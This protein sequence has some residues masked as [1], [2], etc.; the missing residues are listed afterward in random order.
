MQYPSTKSRGSIFWAAV[1]MFFGGII[2]SFIPFLGPFVVGIVGGK[3]AG[4]VGR[5]ITAALL[6]AIVLAILILAG[7]AIL[8]PFGVA[9]GVLAGLGII[10]IAIF[11]SL[12][13]LLGAIIGG[14]L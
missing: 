14:V 9:F 2:F 12:A 4:G 8:H 7:S 3:I 13:L 10:L 5:G 11:H 6:P 1:I